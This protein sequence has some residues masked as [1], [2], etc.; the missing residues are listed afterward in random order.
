MFPRKIA[1]QRRKPAP[2]S[3]LSR[4]RLAAVRAE[5]LK[6][7]PGVWILQEAGELARIDAVRALRKCEKPLGHDELGVLVLIR[8][9]PGCFRVEHLAQILQ[10]DK[11][12]CRLLVR[13]LSEQKLLEAPYTPSVGPLG[14]RVSSPTGSQ[15]YLLRITDEGIEALEKQLNVLKGVSLGKVRAVDDPKSRMKSAYPD[16]LISLIRERISALY[17]IRV[18]A[19]GAKM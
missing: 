17:S 5:Q 10:R 15:N 16:T 3:E 11:K 7:L 6:D 1:Q 14:N 4:A 18:R 12:F 19:S 9:N 8:R 2:V 13:R